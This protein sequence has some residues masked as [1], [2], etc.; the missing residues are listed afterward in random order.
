MPEVTDTSEVEAKVKPD[1]RR[2]DGGPAWSPSLLARVTPG[3]ARRAMPVLLTRLVVAITKS[4]RRRTT[5][6]RGRDSGAVDERCQRRHAAVFRRRDASILYRTCRVWLDPQGRDMRTEE[7]SWP[8]ER[9]EVVSRNMTDTGYYYE[10][11]HYSIA[12]GM[13]E[14]PHT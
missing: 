7:Q 11:E 14:S 5:D 3:R 6:V 13:A 9:E 12:D 1:A 10:E 4:Q 2:A 8:D